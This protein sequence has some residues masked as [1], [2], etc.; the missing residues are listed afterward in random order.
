M[1]PYDIVSKLWIEQCTE[2][3]LKELVGARIKQFQSIEELAQEQP[4]ISKADYV[5]KAELYELAAAGVLA[6]RIP[7]LYPL[8]P[9]MKGGVA[10]AEEANRALLESE[11]PRSKKADLLA[12]LTVFLGLRDKG[13]AAKVRKEQDAHMNVMAESPVYQEILNQGR[14]E[15]EAKG[16]AE[17]RA[18]G[19]RKAIALGLEIRFGAE[20]KKLLPILGRCL[21]L[22]ELERAAEAVKTVPSI[23]DFRRFLPVTR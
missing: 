6:R 5:L 8:I 19:L 13:K 4:A 12:V 7:E 17:G 18:E 15:G 3:F 1:Q 2:P 23:E 21:D 9:L 16:R 10:L 11:L 14:A 22:A 20:A